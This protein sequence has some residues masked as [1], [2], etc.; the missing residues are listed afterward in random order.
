MEVYVARQPIFNA[1][2][3][4]FG[5]E[6]LFREGMSNYFPDIDGSTATSHVLYNSFFTI[7]I[8]KII[9]DNTA[10]INFTE[11]LLV[12]KLPLMFPPEKVVVEVLENVEPKDEV[13]AACKEIADQ[14]YHLALDDFFYNKDLESLIALAN[15]I[16]FDFQAT[17]FEKVS[18]HIEKLS[19]YNV[20]L[21]AEK[22][23][24][25][26]E[27]K[28]A[29]AMGFKLFQGYFF[30]KPEILKGRDIS[31]VQM[32]LLQ[33]MAEV[34]KDNFEFSKVERIISRDVGISYKLLRYMN[35]AYYRR[36]CEISSIKQAI[37]LL[38]E[39]GMRGFVSLIAM[40]KLAAD[41]P[42][43]LVRSSVI[44][45]KFCELMAQFKSDGLDPSELFTI[46]LFSLIDAILDDTMENL[47]G[48]LPLT[49]SIKNALLEKE[50]KLYQYL[51]LSIA[52]QM[53]EWEKVS[54]IANIIRMDESKLPEYFA[55]AV[56]WADGL[57]S[58]R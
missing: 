4:L 40:S 11:D 38:G 33:V 35:S 46:G 22:V 39:R 5:Y 50:G 41:K 28:I 19:K 36:V 51:E 10:F 14:G 24:N 3:E 48:K 12:K 6:L 49:D 26:D 20:I 56:A 18:Q 7:G 1:E 42:D 16:K 43:E 8:D 29:R 9:G 37:V 30:S 44:R 53:A 23:E 45:A 2:K 58:I 47:L 57:T 31:S 32:S 17:S 54:N 55:E 27:F 13:V 52:Y 21:L 25:Y 34:N 15:I